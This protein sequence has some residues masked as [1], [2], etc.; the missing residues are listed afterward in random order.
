MQRA[1]EHGE[2]ALVPYRTYARL[3]RLRPEFQRLIRA[4]YAHPKRPS[5]TAIHE[6]PRL[7]QLADELSA[8]EG[9]V[10]LLPSYLQVY[11]FVSSIRHEPTV[12]DARSGSAHP[13]RPRTSTASYVLSIPAAAQ[14]RQV[15]EHYLDINVVALDGTPLTSRVH[16]A[17]LVRVK[18]AAILGGVLCTGVGTFFR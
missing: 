18:T 16:A 13:P 1:L 2:E 3:R 7:K 8:Q 14:V 5:V 15:D 12:A 17:V 10:V 11:R 9:R 6:H 4:L